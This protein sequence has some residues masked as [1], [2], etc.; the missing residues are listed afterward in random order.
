[1]SHPILNG[2]EAACLRRLAGMYEAGQPVWDIAF[3]PHAETGYRSL[4]LEPHQV[5]PVLGMLEQLGYIEKPTHT[6]NGW[7]IMFTIKGQAIQ[8]VR[9]LEEQDKKKQD[10]D[11]VDHVKTT[12]RKH[13]VWGR[14]IVYGGAVAVIA[15]AVNQIVSLLKN[16]GAF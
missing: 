14:V 1:M 4:G 16:V 12:M 10:R 15:T 13:P 8:G 6:A 11:I 7:F 3:G 2:V 5:R 9:M